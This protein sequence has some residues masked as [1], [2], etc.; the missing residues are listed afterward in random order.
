MKGKVLLG[1]VLL[2]ILFILAAGAHAQAVRGV[3]DTEILVGQTG[4]QT[5]PAALW[6]AVAGDRGCISKG[7]MTRAGFTV[8]RSNISCATTGTNRPRPRPS[9]EFVEQIGIFS[10][11]G[12]V[13][14]GPG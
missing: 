9:E 12:C 7:S 13:G 14:V 10:T 11:V 3:T 8:G 4:P 6:G 2:G 5:G 1:V